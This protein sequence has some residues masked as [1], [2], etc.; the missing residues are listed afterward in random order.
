LKGHG[1]A[2]VPRELDE[3]AA[4][5]HALG[6]RLAAFRQAAGLT[7]SQ[8]ARH[9]YCD[10]TTI[11]HIEKGRRP[12]DERF[13]RAVD[14][15]CH[16][17]GALL[18]ESQELQTA[19]RA[20]QQRRHAEAIAAARARAVTGARSGPA[21]WVAR[22]PDD[23]FVS[24]IVDMAADESSR[25][26]T[27]AEDEN[28]GELT[29][30]Q[31]HAQVR[32][33]SDA[34]LKAPTEPLFVRTKELRDRAF[35]LLAGQQRPSHARDLYAA[36]GWSLTMLAWMSVDLGRPDAAEDHARAAWLCAERA[37][38]DGL[39]AWV[40]A[41]QHTAAF[42]QDD[43]N[44]AAEYAADGLQYVTGSAA[45]F[46]TSANAL[47][48]ARSGQDEQAWEALR[49]AWARAEAVEPTDDELVGPFTCS[50]DRAS[51]LWS[52]TQLTLGA[53]EAAL[54]HAERAVS[55]FDALPPARRNWG[56]ERMVRL[57]K[58][59]AHLALGQLDG[60]ELALAP[61]L[62]TAPEHRVR[63]LLVRMNDVYTAA[64]TARYANEPIAARIRSDVLAFQQAATTRKLVP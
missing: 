37:E 45:L 11:A 10:R 33:I 13:W 25:F 17:E 7:Q 1:E 9:T 62:D 41:T 42:W 20:A 30:E 64:R 3:I 56:S 51:G 8:L 24:H 58:V 2:P 34:Y 36:A 14:N 43:F 4:R 12:A 23:G 19:M 52:D 50:F 26:I 38:H 46:L 55:V 15:T 44:K 35:T 16:A 47:D 6:E 54:E 18:A 48:L 29:L 22:P 40:R 39:R 27:W 5:R 63:P 60:A 57:Q 61:V 21:L 32:R 49:Q 59:R 31:L 53:A 28:V